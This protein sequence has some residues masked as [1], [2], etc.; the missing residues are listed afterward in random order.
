MVKIRLAQIGAKNKRKYRLIVIEEGRRRNGRAIEILG[1]FDPLVKPAHIK[2][3]HQRV[4]Y[5]LSHGAQ[6]TES[7]K[8]LIQ[9]K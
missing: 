1:Y 9:T 4:D 6:A 7:A 8:K 5:W 2:I 3:D